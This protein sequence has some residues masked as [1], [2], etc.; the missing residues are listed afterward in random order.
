MK[1]T[2]L[3]LILLI[4][5]SYN[6]DAVTPGFYDNFNSNSIKY[7]I[8]KQKS[9]AETI[10]VLTYHLLS[11]NKNEFSDY[12]ISPDK[13]EAD[14]K[15]LLKNNYK[16]IKAKDLYEYKKNRTSYMLANNLEEI[17]K[18]AV[19][20]FDDGYDSDYQFVLPILKKYAVPATLFITGS[21]IDK[22]GY[23]TK[24][25]LVELSKENLIEIGNHSFKLHSLSK[26]EIMKKIN[27]ISEIKI[28][29]QDYSENSDYIYKITN[30]LPTSVSYPYGVTNSIFDS[31]LRNKG[32]KATFSTNIG[33]N[34]YISF[35]TTFNRINRSN[36]AEIDVLLKTYTFN[37]GEKWN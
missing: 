28:M 2:A 17:K 23:L 7:N 14:I 36:Y 32:F 30:N 6:V 3:I 15:Y 8:K 5:M 24:S 31:V 19:I 34:K 26:A 4:F 22:K 25:Q 10:L 13:F 1:K 27:L 21:Y 18:I 16:I 37:Y 12:C 11:N 33:D 9:N 29:A 35:N 20:T